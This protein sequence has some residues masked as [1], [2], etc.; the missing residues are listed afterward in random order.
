MVRIGRVSAERGAVSRTVRLVAHACVHP[1]AIILAKGAG[2]FRF[3][4]TVKQFLANFQTL[5]NKEFVF[6]AALNLDGRNSF[7]AFYIFLPYVVPGA[8]SLLPLLI[9]RL[10]LIVAS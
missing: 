9:L 5:S 8:S 7:Q 6:S 4:E 1:A 2:L 10:Y 3:H